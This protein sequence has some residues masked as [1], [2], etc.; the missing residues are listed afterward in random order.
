MI[1]ST[2]PL[3]EREREKEQERK[4]EGEGELQDGEEKGTREKWS[5]RDGRQ[6]K[7]LIDLVNS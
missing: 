4:S 7:V 6:E 3:R 1:R 5:V 2:S